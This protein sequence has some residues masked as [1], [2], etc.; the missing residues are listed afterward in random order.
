MSS[1]IRRIFF[2]VWI[3]DKFDKFWQ[4]SLKNYYTGLT[5]ASV[6]YKIKITTHE[7]QSK[8]ENDTTFYE[9]NK[10]KA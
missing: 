3:F 6:W 8:D 1:A 4:V 7:Q 5:E 9:R 10:N 2:S